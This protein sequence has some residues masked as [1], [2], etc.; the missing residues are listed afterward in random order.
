MP[1]ATKSIVVICEGPADRRTACELADR[2]LYQAIDWFSPDLL[3]AFRHWRGLRANDE[4]LAWK[5]VSSFAQKAN[6]K[7]HGHFDGFPGE[8]DAWMARRALALVTKDAGKGFDAVML[9]RDSDG[10]QARREGLEQ[11]R[12]SSLP[13]PVVIG[14]AHS[15]RESWFLAGFEARDEAERGRLDALK[16]ELGFDPTERAHELNARAPGAKRD[17]KRVLD[18]L[19]GGDRERESMCW[20]ESN[21]EL[22]EARGKE[23]GLAEFLDEIRERLVPLWNGRRP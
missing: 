7:I 21:L 18:T 8:P 6:V 12:K 19:L 3:D 9:I 5:D 14:V 1:E 22:F 23:T 16:R 20:T 15:K 4:F 13:F 2:V 10:N 17:A 11:A